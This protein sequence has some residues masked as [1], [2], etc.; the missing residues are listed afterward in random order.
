VSD[1]PQ[2]IKVDSPPDVVRGTRQRTKEVT[3]L[4]ES[5]KQDGWQVISDISP[6]AEKDKW[7]RKLL[8]ACKVAGRELESFYVSPDNAGEHTPGLYFRGHN[9]G[10]APP[11]GKRRRTR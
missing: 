10:E 11:R 5:V 4:V 1:V 2:I 8:Y 3:A 9:P 6:G 7:Y